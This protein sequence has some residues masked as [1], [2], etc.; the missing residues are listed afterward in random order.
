[1]NDC[2]LRNLYVLVEMLGCGLVA[3]WLGRRVIISTGEVRVPGG[4]S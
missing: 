4:D 1:M 2:Y 3:Q